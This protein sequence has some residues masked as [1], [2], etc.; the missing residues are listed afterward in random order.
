MSPETPAGRAAASLRTAVFLDRDGVLNALNGYVTKPEQLNVFPFAGEAVRL[1]N[2]SGRMAVLATNQPVLARG[3]CSAN[4]LAAIHAKLEA[5][6]GRAGAHLD[7]IYYCPH[8]PDAG[9]PG[10]V[11][12]LKRACD[13][14][15]PKPGL[16]LRAAA[17]LKLDLS[18]SWMIGDS[19]RD[20]M[21]ARACGV[22]FILVRS[23]DAGAAAELE[24]QSDFTFDHVLGAAKFIVG[25]QP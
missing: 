16:L 13:C 2:R 4:G 9:S 24:I 5:V 23:G 11:A 25:A 14:R 10:E 6:L 7:A 20:L 12:E 22:S 15:K 18:R 1:I 8:H 17:D 21:A 3:D 19:A